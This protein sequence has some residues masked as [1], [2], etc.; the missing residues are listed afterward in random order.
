M[1]RR[2]SSG[3]LERRGIRAFQSYVSSPAALAIA[4]LVGDVVLVGMP[5]CFMP[6]LGG[7]CSLGRAVLVAWLVSP[8]TK[9]HALNKV[10]PL[11]GRGVHGNNFSADPDPTNLL[12]LE[13]LSTPGGCPP[14][15]T[16]SDTSCKSPPLSPRK[17]RLSIQFQFQCQL[18]NTP[19][20]S[21][22]RGETLAL[23]ADLA[24]LRGRQVPLPSV[25]QVIRDVSL[26]AAPAN[27]DIHGP[28][29]VGPQTL[30]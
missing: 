20:R 7:A 15:R 25:S 13:C 16:A 17:S 28:D 9:G 29:S 10:R 24:V 8:R 14:T 19:R 12:S 18:T 4:T 6:D 5:S 22:R 1:G 26:G 27:P 21:A 30:R 23:L 11:R 2:P 3:R